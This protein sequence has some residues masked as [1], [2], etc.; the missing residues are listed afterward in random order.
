VRESSAAGLAQQARARGFGVER[1]P[2]R[3]VACSGA[4][5]CASGQ[6]ETR[7]LA[8]EL[9]AVISAAPISAAADLTLHVSGCEKS[10]AWS[11]AAAIT[12]LHGAD[13]MRLGFWASVAETARSAPL[14]VNA[15]RQR[16]AARFAPERTRGMQPRAVAEGPQL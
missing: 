8:S 5:A 9:A 4:P 6:G 2:L 16:I 10:C 11:G 3:L 1:N 14:D 12:V 15:V 7:R 13:G